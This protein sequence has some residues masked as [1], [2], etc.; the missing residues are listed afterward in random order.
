MIA[1]AISQDFQLNLYYTL[2]V[3][4]PGLAFHTIMRCLECS[5]KR[6]LQAGSVGIIYKGFGEVKKN[7]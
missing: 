5:S 1:E 2:N 4:V 6:H 7:L 3:K